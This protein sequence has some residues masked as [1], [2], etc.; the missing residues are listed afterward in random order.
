MLD[1]V[2][3]IEDSIGGTISALVANNALIAVASCLLKAASYALSL[4]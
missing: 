1:I 2:M 4:A 3:S